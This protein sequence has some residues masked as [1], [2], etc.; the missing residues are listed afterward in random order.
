MSATIASISGWIAAES[1]ARPTTA[2]LATTTS[3]SASPSTTAVD[4]CTLARLGASTVGEARPSALDCARL[5]FFALGSAS[6]LAFLLAGSA[7]VPDAAGLSA[8]L[9]V[10]A[11]GLPSASTLGLFF[12]P[13]LRPRAFLVLRDQ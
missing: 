2:D 9:R 13:G 8:R 3:S 7:S 5:D 11:T 10:G 6:V 1:A 4:E 12:E